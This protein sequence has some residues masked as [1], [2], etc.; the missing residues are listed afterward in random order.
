MSPVQVDQ[1]IVFADIAGSSRLFHEQG[2][3]AA[4]QLINTTLGNLGKSATSLQGVVVKTIGDELML[5]YDTPDYAAAAMRE[6]QRFLSKQTTPLR[7]KIG[8][9]FGPALVGAT[10]VYGE[11]V[12]DAACLVRIAKADQIIISNTF[13]QAL[14]PAQQKHCQI[15]DF[16]YLKGK[17]QRQIIYRMNCEQQADTNSTTQVIPVAGMTNEQVGVAHIKLTVNGKTVELSPGDMPYRFGRDRQHVDC[18]VPSTLASRQHCELLFRRHKYVLVDHSTNGTF[19]QQ[20]NIGEVYLRREETPLQG[21]GQIAFGQR[22]AQADS[23]T[24]HYVVE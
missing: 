20:D 23:T 4:S 2:D 16:T 19:I 15:Y 13:F 3:K 9:S 14:S 17:Q 18:F 21:C 11:T 5:R 24:V 12:N 22:S 6:M 8:A 7:L 1:I 10:D